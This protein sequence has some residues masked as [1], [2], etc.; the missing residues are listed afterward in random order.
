MGKIQIVNGKVLIEDGKVKIGEDCNCCGIA[1]RTSG[2]FDQGTHVWSPICSTEIAVCISGQAGSCAVLNT[3]DAVVLT[4]TVGGNPS[5]YVYE[6]AGVK[7]LEMTLEVGFGGATLGVLTTYY[8]DGSAWVQCTQDGVA[9]TISMNNR[10]GYWYT[11]SHARRAWALNSWIPAYIQISMA[12]MVPCTN[13]NT[14]SQ[15]DD[16]AWGSWQY[17]NFVG[18]NTTHNLTKLAIGTSTP[19]G[20]TTEYLTVYKVISG[21]ADV[22]AWYNITSRDCTGT[23]DVEE[24]ADVIWW[25][26]FSGNAAELLVRA[27]TSEFTTNMWVMDAFE[28]YNDAFTDANFADDYFSIPCAGETKSTFSNSI[29]CPADYTQQSGGE[30]SSTGDATLIIPTHGS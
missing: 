20:T 30:A 3:V 27:D 16:Y 1:C 10:T 6:E 28:R 29:T 21:T 5:T 24:T 25:V 9:P 7:K 13:C 26:A 4:R 8:W 23:P 19:F 22:T 14:R 17:S 12:N 11:A 18:V 15:L 2:A